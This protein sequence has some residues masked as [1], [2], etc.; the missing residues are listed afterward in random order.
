MATNQ[1]PGFD[2]KEI[3]EL[4]AECREE[5]ISFVYI[6]DPDLDMLESGECE[7]IQF[8]GTYKGQDVIY[9]ALVYTLR[10]HH[11]SMVYE[12]AVEQLKTS[13]PSYVPPEERKAN[14]KISPEDEE[15]AETALTELIEELEE[16]EAVKVQE[17]VELD[18]E[19]D[20]GIALDVC[21]NVEEIN[22]EV[23]EEFIQNFNGGTLKLDTT[24]YS[25]TEDGEE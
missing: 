8:V 17:H 2:P 13:F 4:R 6:E 1:N 10:L 19:S 15:E 3:E 20:Y 11:S 16:T 12:M 21:L 25:F 9:D 22:E 24:L 5:G 7:H 23:I 18:L 14:Y